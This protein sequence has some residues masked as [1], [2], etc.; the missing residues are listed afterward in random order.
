V[1]LLQASVGRPPLSS[2]GGGGDRS[3]GALASEGA[4]ASD[5]DDDEPTPAASPLRSNIAAGSA[6]S[7]DT[8]ASIDD[9][10]DI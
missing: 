1:L 2:G 10:F 6:G 4:V 9:N 3:E 8:N 7:D 5:G